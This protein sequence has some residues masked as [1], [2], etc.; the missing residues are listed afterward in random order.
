MH[1]HAEH[2]LDP[3]YLP[4][5]DRAPDSAVT[6]RKS[7]NVVI[8]DVN[9]RM[10]VEN[11]ARAFPA[12]VRELLDGGDRRFAVS[13]GGVDD[14]DSYGLGALAAAY[15]WIAEAGGEMVLYG[16]TPRVRRTLNRLRLDSVIAVFDEGEEALRALARARSKP[17]LRRAG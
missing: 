14:I 16:A 15:N 3:G 8:V 12:Y 10:T 9:A 6:Y 5:I 4:S 11:T 7:G 17:Q 13:L 1:S 2:A